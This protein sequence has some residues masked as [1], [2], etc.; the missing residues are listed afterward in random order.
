MPGTPA[1]LTIRKQRHQFALGQ[2]AQG[3]P[4]TQVVAAIAEEWGCS[5]RQARNVARAALD[6]LANDIDTMEFKSL[7][8]STINRLERLANKAENAGQFAPAVG[9]VNALSHLVLLPQIE[10]RMRQPHWGNYSRS[11]HG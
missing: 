11:S 4:Y 3:I 1:P 2:L 7:L 10:K 6:E 9:A 8:A 5:R